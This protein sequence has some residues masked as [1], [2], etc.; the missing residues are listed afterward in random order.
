V[1][2]FEITCSTDKLENLSKQK[3]PLSRF[4]LPPP[5]SIPEME[6]PYRWKEYLS[7][8]GIVLLGLIVIL[9]T[10]KPRSKIAIKIPTKLTE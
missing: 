2:K 1:L 7:I 9:I 4:D 10:S 3:T 5:I 8:V 6:N